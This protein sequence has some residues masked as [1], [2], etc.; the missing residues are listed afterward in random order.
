MTRTYL[1][2]L[3]SFSLSGLSACATGPTLEEQDPILALAP[4][5]SEEQ[6]EMM[7]ERELLRTERVRSARDRADVT[8]G[9]S[10]Q[11]VLASWGQPSDVEKAGTRN[12]GNERW[13]YYQ[14]LTTRWSMRS[15]RIVYFESGQ[16]V[17][18]ETR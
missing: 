11:D 13:I 7:E 17:G 14:G 10:R 18:W 9:M 4:K 15:A 5:I 3:I 6:R 2:L 12:T 16:V 1:I 8:L